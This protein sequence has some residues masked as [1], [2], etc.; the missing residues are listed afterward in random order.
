[1]STTVAVETLTI[2]VEQAIVRAK[3][4]ITHPVLA[5]VPQGGIFPVLETQESWDKILLKDGRE[6]WIARQVGRVEQEPR[7]LT[8]VSPPTC[9]ARS[10]EPA[11]VGNRQQ[12]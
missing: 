1:V 8:V 3:P 7:K 9:S 11:G 10:P 4:G 2:T 12:C 6:G 5:V